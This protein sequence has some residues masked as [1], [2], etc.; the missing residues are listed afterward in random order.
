MGQQ[1]SRNATDDR[2]L[3]NRARE[4]R[5][6]QAPAEAVHWRELRGRRLTG[7]KFR[8]QNVVGEYVVDFYCAEC[9]LVIE[10][11]GETHTGKEVAD[12]VRQSFLESRGLKMLRFWNTDVYD[13]L[14]GVLSV[15]LRECAMRR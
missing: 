15:I 11:D 13:N 8:R 7:F 4:L 2:W 6:E 5:R 10:L 3:L 9:K 14:D 12:R 1:V